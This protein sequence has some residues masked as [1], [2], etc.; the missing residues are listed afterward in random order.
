MIQV[1]HDLILGDALAAL[2]DFCIHSATPM[3]SH[4]ILMRQTGT[5]STELHNYALSKYI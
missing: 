3:D 5:T 2:I 4:Y 1:L